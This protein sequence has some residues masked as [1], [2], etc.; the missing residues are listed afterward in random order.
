MEKK[1]SNNLGL[2]V[3]SVFLAFFVWLAVMNI[4]NP[5]VMRSQEVPLEILNGDILE[6]SGK[7]YEVIGDRDTVTVYY[8]VTTS[9]SANIKASDFRAYIDLADVYEPTG[10]VP[11]KLEVKNNSNKL[12]SVVSKPS[13]IRIETED[14]QRKPFN[15]E[16]KTEGVTEDGYNPGVATVS[17]TYIYVSG[18]VSVV[19]RISS[20][21]IVINVEGANSDLSGTLP[22]RCFDAN[23]NDLTDQI[24]DR[25]TFSRS[26]ID[27]TLPILKE[28]NLNL[29]FETEGTVADG[30]RFTGI[31]SSRNYVEVKGLKSDLARANSVTIP[32]S[33]L[34]MDGA[35]GD[36]EV[37]IDLNKYLPEGVELADPAANEI[38]VVIKVESLESRTYEVPVSQIKQVGASGQYDY[39]YDRKS[40]NIVIEG[41][42]EDLDQLT[43]AAILAELD[44]SSMEPGDNMGTVTLELGD[45]YEL[46]SGNSVLVTVTEKGPSAPDGEAE[47]D[48]SQSGTNEA[49]ESVKETT[50]A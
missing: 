32:K 40:L 18:P 14:L 34:N 16:T 20:V 45:A 12:E 10:A 29:T 1:L 17:P 35:T 24:G 33:E 39:E 41:L 5:K 50:G 19:G 37:T 2:K 22:V 21:G 36:K 13:V 25:V 31:E 30:Y 8:K 44:V 6:S 27:Y 26:E 7:T 4:A 15:L 46:V 11:V 48:E 42:K 23:N 43:P 49:G 47:E 3:L 38:K 9:D 28:K